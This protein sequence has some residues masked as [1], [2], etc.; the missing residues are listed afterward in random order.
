MSPYDGG[1]RMETQELT[2]KH[3]IMA[4]GFFDSK[5]LLPYIDSSAFGGQVYH[6]VD[7]KSAGRVPD[8]ASKTVTIIGSS[9]TGHDIAQDFV[10]HGAKAVNMIQRRASWVVSKA[11]AEMQFAAYTAPGVTTEEADLIFSAFPN[12]VLRSLA[13][14][15]I[16]MT[17]DFD[18]E[19]ITNLERAGFRVSRGED[20]SS[21]FDRQ[22]IS[23]GR[24]YIDHGASQMIIDGRIKVHQSPDGVG[25]LDSRGV[26]LEESIS[27]HSDIVVYATGYKY[28]TTTI[29]ELLDEELANKLVEN[30]AEFDE[31]QERP[32]VSLTRTEVPRDTFANQKFSLAMAV[33]WASWILGFGRCY[34]LDSVV[35][36]GS[37][38]ADQSN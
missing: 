10:H 20:G 2:A 16:P 4:T 37:R 26:V 6:A 17:L 30:F 36:R 13:H 9:T 28:L 21:V 31:E 7:H 11:S 8:L 35:H 24:Y 32:G 1:L 33:H 23:R 34:L 12:S 25:K 22:L 18:K 19:L 5:P 27:V 38:P 14:V 3:V 15:S 29:K